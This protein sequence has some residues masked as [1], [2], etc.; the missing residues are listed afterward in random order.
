MIVPHR[1]EYSET[2]AFHIQGPNRSFVYMPDVDKWERLR[3]TRIEALIQNVDLAFLDGT[4]FTD[5]ELAGRAM[6]QIPHP[7]IA[8]S[9][10][11]FASLPA[12]ER[13][14]IHFIHFNHTNPVLQPGHARIAEVERAGMHI[15]T[16]G[17]QFRI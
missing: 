6:S 9:L 4:F 13:D 11:R 12:S 5:E 3:T 7:F 17:Q 10:Q 16:E 2:V 8:E 14:K 1:D 15:S